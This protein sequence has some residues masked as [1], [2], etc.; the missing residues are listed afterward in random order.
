MF[1]AAVDVN[2]SDLCRFRLLLN[3]NTSALS[4]NSKSHTN[5]T[6]GNNLLHPNYIKSQITATY[7]ELMN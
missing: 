6:C 2:L 4:P 3:V 5:T 7:N 1:T